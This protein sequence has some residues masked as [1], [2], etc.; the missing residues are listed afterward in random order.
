MV[1]KKD[2]GRQI[3]VSEKAVVWPG[4]YWTPCIQQELAR[5]V[6]NRKP[7]RLIGLYGPWADIELS[8]FRYMIAAKDVEVVS[9]GT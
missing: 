2:I 8:V 3:L 1:T 9:D 7:G 6:R 4:E 5:C